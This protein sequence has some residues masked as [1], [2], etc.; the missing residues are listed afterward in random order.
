MGAQSHLSSPKLRVSSARTYR[1]LVLSLS[2]SLLYIRFI[3][4]PTTGYTDKRKCGAD[5]GGEIASVGKHQV[6]VPKVPATLSQLFPRPFSHDF[7][8]AELGLRKCQKG[9]LDA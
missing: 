5:I 3:M 1:G 7:S 9:G 2:L 8:T 4:C 6:F